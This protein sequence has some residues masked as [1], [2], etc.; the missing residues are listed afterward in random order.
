MDSE[1]DRYEMF[2]ETLVIEETEVVAYGVR[3]L[4]R[5]VETYRCA[6]LSVCEQKVRDLVDKL[7]KMDARS[8]HLEDIFQDFLP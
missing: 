2:R 4:S 5:D 8:V 3:L 7:N 6:D 1:N